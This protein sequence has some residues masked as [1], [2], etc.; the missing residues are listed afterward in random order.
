MAVDDDITAAAQR[1]YQLRGAQRQQIISELE[2][3]K[4]NYDTE[5]MAVKVQEIADWDAG[6]R[7]LV[8]AHDQY[9]ASQQPR[10]YAPESEEEFRARPARDVGDALRMLNNTSKYLDPRQGGKP[11]NFDDPYVRAGMAEVEQRRRTG[12]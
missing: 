12:R 8:A 1:A 2:A 9:V 4:A 5:L 11:L 3:A 10:Y 6:T 7:N